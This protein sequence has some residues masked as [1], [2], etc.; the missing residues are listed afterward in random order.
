MFFTVEFA[1][2]FK[3]KFNY[4]YLILVILLSILLSLKISDIASYFEVSKEVIV[5]DII[6]R[7]LFVTVLFVMGINYIYSYR[8]DY[9]SKVVKLLKIAKME[10]RKSFSAVI[11]N[12]LYFTFY[13]MFILA[14]VGMVLVIRDK[15]VLRNLVS[16]FKVNLL[17]YLLLVV[18]L[19][20]FANLIFLLI[21]SIFNDTNLA[22]ALSFLYFIGI[23]PLAAFLKTK[24]ITSIYI[25]NSLDIFTNSLVKL[26]H[27]LTFSS[28]VWFYL[29]ANMIAVTILIV[30]IRIIKK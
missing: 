7:L 9:Q 25:D 8:Q 4:S 15:D 21:L 1:K 28:T 14:T 13:Y 11:S 20:L 26:N 17:A 12:T 2:I 18:V 23:T 6:A 30:V 19:L 10:T 16:S 3:R 22:I 27:S 24:G 29:V 5:S